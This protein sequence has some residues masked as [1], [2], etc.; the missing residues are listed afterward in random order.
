MEIILHIINSMIHINIT[1]TYNFSQHVQISC[2]KN[3]HAKNQILCLT[4]SFTIPLHKDKVK[5]SHTKINHIFSHN[6]NASAEPHNY[7]IKL[8]FSVNKNLIYF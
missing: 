1:F 3:Q 2:L 7:P 6:K 8:V 5:V 4:T